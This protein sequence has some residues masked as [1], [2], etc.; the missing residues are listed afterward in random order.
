[1]VAIKKVKRIFDD[2]VDCKRMLREIAILSELEDDRIVKLLD[3]IV[4]GNH[5]TFNELYL[6]LELC[7]TD[8]K[9][10]FRLGE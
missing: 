2:L 4:P 9:K 5:A 8:L 1:M 6:V 7:D 3:V 10:L